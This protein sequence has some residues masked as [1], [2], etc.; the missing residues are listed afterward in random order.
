M[1]EDFSVIF[2]ENIFV[3]Q[4]IIEEKFQFVGS[5]FLNLRLGGS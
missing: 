3:Q 5:I 1:T 4:K 2:H